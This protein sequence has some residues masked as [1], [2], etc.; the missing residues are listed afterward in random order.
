[1][2]NIDKG[3]ALMTTSYR[4][5]SSLFYRQWIRIWDPCFSTRD[6]CSSHARFRAKVQGLHFTIRTRD[7]RSAF[8]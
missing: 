3:I 6:S 1:M 5:G 7:L 2:L 4:F 8:G